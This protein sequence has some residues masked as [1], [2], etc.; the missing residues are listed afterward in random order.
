M[1]CIAEDIHEKNQ[2]NNGFELSD[3]LS[4]GIVNSILHV[5]LGMG[6]HPYS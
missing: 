4:T 1:H 2:Y 6:V 3:L 5:K